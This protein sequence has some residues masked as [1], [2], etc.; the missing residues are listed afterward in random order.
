MLR[1]MAAQA[2][3]WLDGPLLRPLRRIGS[4]LIVV[5]GPWIL[6]IVTL[7]LIGWTTGARLG[8]EALEDMRLAVVYAF[9]LAPLI[10][11]PMGVIGARAVTDADTPPEPSALAAL[12]L[13][14]CGIAGVSA[15]ILALVVALA[16]GLAD[17]ALT[18]AFVMLTSAS[19]MM[20]TAFPI[21]AAC[22]ARRRLITSF[23]FGMGLAL[24]LCI[25]VADHTQSSA[26]IV[27]CFTAGISLCL[28]LS[29][30]PFRAVGLGADDMRHAIGWL[31]NGVRTTWPLGLG[32]A[33]A[34]AAVWTD[35]WVFWLGPGG[36][37][38]AA[39]FLHM[40]SYDSAMFL[41][42]L[43]AIPTLAALAM[44]F[45]GPVADAMARFRATLDRGGSLAAAE[46]AAEALS[47]TLWVGL[48]RIMVGMLALAIALFLFAPTVASLAGLRL[49]QFLLFRTGIVGVLLHALFLAASSVLILC[50]RKSA[51]VLLQ[52]AFFLTNAGL[53]VFL[54]A[55]IGVTALGFALGAAT[56]GVAATLVAHVTVRSLIQHYFITGNDALFG[57]NRNS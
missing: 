24:A 41:V 36:Q 18:L 8:A 14:S 19:A 40:P 35:K 26:N 43:C 16:L 30:A 33:F 3:W 22:R 38:S 49:D 10:A 7:V 48:L 4:T 46:R 6:A 55:Q 9:M 5:A 17:G 12:M 44:H 52:A 29:F 54:S 20:W 51:F 23:A 42:H 56:C 50:N 47:A 45:D 13:V 11:T 37:V 27:W 1:A 53:T 57:A 34:I 32:A 28:G 31:S 39:G 15:E 25:G 2:D 21:L